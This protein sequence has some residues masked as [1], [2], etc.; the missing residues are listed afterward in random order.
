MTKEDYVA[1]FPVLDDE[2]HIS[3]MLSEAEDALAGML[4]A[5][6]LVQAGPYRWAL[7]EPPLAP[8]LTLMLMVPVYCLEVPA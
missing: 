6:G 2:Q 5:D 3:G 8:R 4:E 7:V 1:A